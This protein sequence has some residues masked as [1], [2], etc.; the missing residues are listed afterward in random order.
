MNRRQFL[1]AVFAPFLL[2]FVP[3]SVPP[4]SVQAR[5]NWVSAESL[6]ILANQI[7]LDLMNWKFGKAAKIKICFDPA[8]L[9]A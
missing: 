2:R 3:R 8:R 1:V 4:T 5:V 7:D 6:R 9:P